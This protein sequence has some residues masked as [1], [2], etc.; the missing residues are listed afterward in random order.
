VGAANWDSVEAILKRF[1]AAHQL[2]VYD[3]RQR[4]GLVLD[5][6][7]QAGGRSTTKLPSYAFD[8]QGRF[9][10]EFAS[11]LVAAAAVCE[12]YRFEHAGDLAS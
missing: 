10:G 8:H 12:R 2:S 1:P 5:P 11:R 6:N 9:V 7:E 3:G 4:L